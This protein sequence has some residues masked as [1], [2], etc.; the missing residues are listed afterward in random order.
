MD[1][2]V[3][4]DVERND[5]FLLARANLDMARF[6]R[7]WR[8]TTPDHQNETTKCE[9]K[10]TIKLSKRSGSPETN[11]KVFFEFASG[12]TILSSQLKNTEF[13]AG[14][15]VRTYDKLG[16][17]FGGIVKAQSRGDSFHIE[18]RKSLQEHPPLL[19]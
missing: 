7:N 13:D 1:F 8:V 15:L 6:I 17:L 11:T 18:T 19:R 2:N 3:N 5:A 16:K 10:I 12:E 4:G 9:F 14:E